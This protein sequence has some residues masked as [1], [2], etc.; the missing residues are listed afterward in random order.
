MAR[1][2]CDC[3]QGLLAFFVGVGGWLLGSSGRAH[4]RGLLLDNTP[5]KS[6]F[7]FELRGSTKQT[8]QQ[9]SDLILDALHAG[10]IHFDFCTSGTHVAIHS[11]RYQL[12]QLIQNLFQHFIRSS[13]S[14][15]AE[16]LIMQRMVMDSSTSLEVKGALGSMAVHHHH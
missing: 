10:L 11:V 9:F 1:S 8:T 12:W 16:H 14:V 3:S 6:F 15:I 4:A 2:L 7:H 13:V 5:T